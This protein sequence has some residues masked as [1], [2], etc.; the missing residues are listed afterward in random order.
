MVN[1][2]VITNK[3]AKDTKQGQ[4]FMMTEGYENFVPTWENSFFSKMKNHWGQS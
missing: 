3:G 2:G 1:K 4:S